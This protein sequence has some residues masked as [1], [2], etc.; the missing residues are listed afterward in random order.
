[1]NCHA[2][3]F[4]IDPKRTGRNIRTLC[5]ARGFTVRDLQDFF[6]FDAPQAIYKWMNGQSLPNHVNFYALS[7]LLGVTID[8]IMTADIR[9]DNIIALYSEPQEETCGPVLF[10]E[11]TKEDGRRPSLRRRSMGLVPDILKMLLG[12]MQRAC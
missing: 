2:Y 1:M 6:G 10:C 9:A 12:V 7:R 4:S 5:S 8:E 3:D 11:E